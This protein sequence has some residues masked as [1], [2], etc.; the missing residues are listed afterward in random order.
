MS[1]SDF[2]V[3]LPSDD[4]SRSDNQTKVSRNTLTNYR[5][6][7]PSP[8][9]LN[10]EW[11]VALVELMYTKSWFNFPKTELI[12]FYYYDV[13]PRQKWVQTVKIQHV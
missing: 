9:D 7:L 13:T 12:H 8:L 6:T 10:G 2:Y 3:F 5:T 1:Q 11:E 4:S